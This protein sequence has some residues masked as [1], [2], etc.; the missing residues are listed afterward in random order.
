MRKMREKLPEM[1]TELK[2]VCEMEFVVEEEVQVTKKKK[3]IN[4]EL[5]MVLVLV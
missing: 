4:E 2:S 1:K 3:K 5:R